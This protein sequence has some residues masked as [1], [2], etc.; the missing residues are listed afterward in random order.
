LSAFIVRYW[1]PA[2]C[3]CTS[4]VTVGPSQPHIQWVKGAV[5]H[6]LKQPV[7]EANHSPPSNIEAKKEWIYPFILS[8]RIHGACAASFTF[9]KVTRRLYL[10]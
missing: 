7:R 3:P 8:I 2:K 1:I 6:G 5:S 9:N 4:P 10:E